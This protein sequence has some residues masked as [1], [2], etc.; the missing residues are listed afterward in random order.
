MLRASTY[1]RHS[2]NNQETIMS[3]ETIYPILASKSSN[4]HMIKR[5]VKFVLSCRHD[6]RDYTEK[7]HI[8]PKADD[9]FPEYK[10]FK[11]YPWN[12]AILTPRQHI[13][14]HVMLW[15]IFGGSQTIAIDFIL[16]IQ[17]IKRLTLSKITV[18]TSIEIRYA[19][20]IAEESATIKSDRLK[21]TMR[22]M[23]QDGVY[24]GRYHPDDP[25]IKELNLIYQITDGHKNQWAD[26]SKLAIIAN[27]GTKLY[28][29]GIEEKKFRT[30][31]TD[32]QWIL[33][34]LPRSEEYS[35]KHIEATKK[36]NS[37]CYYWNNG[38]ICKKIPIDEHP[39]DGWIRG[40]LPRDTTKQ[41]KGI[42]EYQSGT[43]YWNNGIIEIKIKSDASLPPGNWVRGRLKR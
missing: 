5:Y 19:A 20:K 41:S 22:Y 4:Y 25:I 11:K 17:R 23:T 15:K 12:C 1:S 7:H 42:S 28:N 33:G 26:R 35:K 43:Q 6:K 13:I 2:I 21:E 8:C 3:S 34:R 38:I 40:M 9:L 30:P 31:P 16:N 29:N 36:K 37:G 10:D 14:A 18:P 32:P 39:G 27:T 24:H